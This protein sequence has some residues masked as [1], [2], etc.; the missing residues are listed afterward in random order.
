MTQLLRRPQ[1]RGYSLITDPDGGTKHRENDSVTCGHCQH[2]TFIPHM[3]RPEDIGMRC[4][5]CDFLLCVPC[6]RAYTRTLLCTHIE[7][8]LEAIEARDRLCQA[9]GLR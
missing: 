1:A 2:I 8:R 9:M 5:G 3:C 7:K 6:S 4:G